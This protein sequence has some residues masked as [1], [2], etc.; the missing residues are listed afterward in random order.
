[1]VKCARKGFIHFSDMVLYQP[2]CT[3]SV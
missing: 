2:A 1:M 3:V